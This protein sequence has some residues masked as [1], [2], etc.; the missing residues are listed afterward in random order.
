MTSES[1]LLSEPTTDAPRKKMGKGAKLLLIVGI[2]LG[3]L[4]FTTEVVLRIA[5]P[6]AVS[7]NQLMP[8][9][10]KAQS[11]RRGMAH[12][13]LAFIPR[14]NWESPPTFDHVTTHNSW[15][16]RG[17]EVEIEKPEDVFRIVCLG[18]S[19][20]YGH[21]PSRDETT[22]PAQLQTIL[23][24]RQDIKRVEVING[25]FSGY[26]S[27]ESLA[28]FNFR[29]LP[30]DPDLVIVYHTIN[31]ARCTLYKNT[32][33]YDNTHWRSVWPIYSPTPTE[34][35]FETSMTYLIYRRYLT[36]YISGMGDMGEW[37]IVDYD[38][39]A[40][41]VWKV[42]PK[43][44]IG[45]QNFQRN[46][47]SIHASAAARGIQMVVASQGC[48]RTDFPGNGA[49]QFGA[50]DRNETILRKVAAAKELLFVEG[51]EA[52]DNAAKA[53]GVDTVYTH[54]VHLAFA[55]A[56]LQSGAIQ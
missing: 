14:P 18:G 21:T 9:F 32:A 36:D 40:N 19:S 25:G 44:K 27:F 34:K 24:E 10:L 31:D 39:D 2:N 16:F 47:E 29:L 50:L 13:Y 37:G 8:A 51:R 46:L 3:L 1:P 45:F 35:L 33:T 11:G 12:P 4:L 52:L 53:E 48:D 22:W 20:T 15:G 26:N 43:T 49:I 56:L 5:R 38:P 55:K 54:E 17:P 30:F 6:D 41:D 23:N 28:N 7:E 42:G